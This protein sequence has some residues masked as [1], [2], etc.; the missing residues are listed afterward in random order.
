MMT[1]DFAH[2]PDPRSALRDGA[3]GPELLE[4]GLWAKV[5][6]RPDQRPRLV[7]ADRCDGGYAVAFYGSDFSTIR[8]DGGLVVPGRFYHVHGDAVI[9]GAASC[10]VDI[11]PLAAVPAVA[12][13]PARPPQGNG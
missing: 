6:F 10:S 1:L 12:E 13:Q 5:P 2:M 8:L 9:T 11:R 3:D 7:I 4:P